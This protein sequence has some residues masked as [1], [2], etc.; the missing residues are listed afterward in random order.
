M[1]MDLSDTA[2]VL[3]GVCEVAEAETLLAWLQAHPQGPVDVSG[4]EH[5]HTALVQV[6]IAARPAVTGG[7]GGAD[8]PAWVEALR[9]L[10]KAV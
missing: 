10:G 2:A 9:P 1:P 7:S 3:V 5:A 8:A 4:C 6:L